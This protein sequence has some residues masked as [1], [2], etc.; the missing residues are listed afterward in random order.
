MAKNR[1]LSSASVKRYMIKLYLRN[2][3]KLSGQ[4]LWNGALTPGMAKVAEEL[5][6]DEA[7]NW[8]TNYQLYHRVK[9]IVKAYCNKENIPTRYQGLLMAYAEKIVANWYV[10]YKGE[11]L[12]ALYANYLR[13][14]AYIIEAQP[15]FVIHTSNKNTGTPDNIDLTVVLKRIT[16]LV[17][18]ELGV[19]PSSI[20]IG[21]EPLD[22]V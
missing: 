17:L 14:L 3:G 13:K 6:Y 1:R 15:R 4:G 16:R 18:E 19:K 7:Q 8:Y 22:R 2:V 21:N 20:T 10:D 11:L 9:Q 12:S 5:A